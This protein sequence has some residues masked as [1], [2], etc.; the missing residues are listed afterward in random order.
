[1]KTAD[2]SVPRLVVTVDD[3]SLLNKI[4]NAIKLL[5]GVGNIDV[6]KP[7]KTELDMAREDKEKGRVTK[8]DSV[9][10]MFDKVLEI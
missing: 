9:D 2:I 6:L 8:W 4:K 7:E 3:A 1:M 10:K 5:N